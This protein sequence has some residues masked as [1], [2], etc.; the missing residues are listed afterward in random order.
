MLT[1]GLE[2]VSAMTPFRDSA[3]CDAPGYMNLCVSELEVHFI[4]PGI[5]D[6]PPT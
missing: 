2:S 6:Y 1:A 5:L 4:S 3:L